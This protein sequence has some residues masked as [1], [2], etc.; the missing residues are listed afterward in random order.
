MDNKTV[1]LVVFVP[2][3]HAEIVRRALG[4]VGAGLVGNYSHCT[5]SVSGIGRYIPMDSAHPFIGMI[6]KLEEVEEERIETVC[7]EKDLEKIIAAVKKVHPYEKVAFDV[8]PL[9]LNPHQIINK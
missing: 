2:Q 5:F 7:Y 1:K 6:G 8:Y 3:T 9:I 4:E